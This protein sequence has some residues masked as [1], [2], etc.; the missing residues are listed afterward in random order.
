M[1]CLS[2]K[3]GK[4]LSTTPKSMIIVSSAKRIRT[5]MWYNDLSKHPTPNLNI[6]SLRYV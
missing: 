4:S 6:P 5:S 1:V 3:S 2:R